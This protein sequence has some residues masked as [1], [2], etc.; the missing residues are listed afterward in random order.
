MDKVTLSFAY[1]NY[2]QPFSQLNSGYKPPNPYFAAS[3]D[4]VFSFFFAT[5][6]YLEVGDILSLRL[7]HWSTYCLSTDDGDYLATGSAGD[8][9][10]G[11]VDSGTSGTGEWV[12]CSSGVPSAAAPWFIDKI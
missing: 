8:V 4:T 3:M 1:N 2:L 12:Q 10:I 6:I 11:T 9:N 7:P 5:N